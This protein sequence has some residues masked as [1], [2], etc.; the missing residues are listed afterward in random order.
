MNCTNCL[1]SVNVKIEQEPFVDTFYL[2]CLN[3]QCGE[4]RTVKLEVIFA[5]FNRLK[6][7]EGAINELHYFVCNHATTQRLSATC[8]Q[9]DTLL[10]NVENNLDLENNY[11]Q[12]VLNNEQSTTEATA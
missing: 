8:E 9:F 10:I 4:R 3:P 2:C 1:E 12:I 7:L 5:E 11:K 6:K